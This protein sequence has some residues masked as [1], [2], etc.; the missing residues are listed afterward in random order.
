MPL[1]RLVAVILT[2]L[3]GLSGL[4][5]GLQLLGTIPSSSTGPDGTAIAIGSGIAAYGGVATIAAVGLWRGSRVAWWVSAST[6]AVGLIGLIALVLVSGSGGLLD[7]ILAGGALVWAIAL[8][9]HLAPS[10]RASVG[11]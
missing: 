10:T 9:A 5:A 4:A 6:I 1:A 3:I 8:V 11:V 2:G 7:S